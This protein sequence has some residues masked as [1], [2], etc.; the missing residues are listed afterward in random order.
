MRCSKEN[1][2]R[3]VT[4]AVKQA[5]KVR[6]DASE[7]LT[8]DELTPKRRARQ[9]RSV[10]AKNH[11]ALQTQSDEGLWIEEK[12]TD[13]VAYML[14]Q[15]MWDMLYELTLPHALRILAERDAALQAAA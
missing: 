11:A 10:S 13:P 9:T 8:F 7:D 14:Y 5:H 15:R 2:A 1:T 6:V 12:V 4:G 3:N